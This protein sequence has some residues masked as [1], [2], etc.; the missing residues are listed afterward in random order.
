MVMPGNKKVGRNYVNDFFFFNIMEVNEG[1]AENRLNVNEMHKYM[2]KYSNQ[3]K[4][5]I[6]VNTMKKCYEDSKEEMGITFFPIARDKMAQVIFP[7]VYL[8]KEYVLDKIADYTV[9]LIKKYWKAIKRK[10]KGHGE[11]ECEKYENMIMDLHRDICVCLVLYEIFIKEFN[12][13]ERALHN[14]YNRVSVEAGMWMEKICSGNLIGEE[15][16]EF[17]RWQ[18]RACLQ[19][20]CFWL[21]QMLQ[22]HERMYFAVTQCMAFIGILN[23]EMSLPIK[24][25]RKIKSKDDCFD[26][27][28]YADMGNKTKKE[29]VKIA[30]ETLVKSPLFGKDKLDQNHSTVKNILIFLE[31]I[32]ETRNGTGKY[33]L[34]KMAREISDP[35]MD[36][37]GAV[38]KL[39]IRETDYKNLK[40]KIEKTEKNAT[41]QEG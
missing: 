36:R 1:L 37:L 18:K 15:A 2:I 26:A 28:I 19:K 7:R 39:D 13:Q 10:E 34:E 27:L 32:S 25:E 38:M 6:N 16:E 24:A 41:V 22:K 35:I 30:K 11:K 20:D 14:E 8:D 23:V 5:N 12:A 31:Q 29:E 3:Y 33:A 4:Y 21:I 9:L 17:V 40:W